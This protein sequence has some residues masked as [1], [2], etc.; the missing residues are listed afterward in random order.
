MHLLP[1]VPEQHSLQVRTAAH[2]PLTHS[3]GD[4]GAPSLLLAG[5]DCTLQDRALSP[6]AKHRPLQ[7][8]YACIDMDEEA[9]ELA[10]WCM[11]VHT[12]R[13]GTGRG[14][15]RVLFDFEGKARVLMDALRE[16]CAEKRFPNPRS[17]VV[18]LNDEETVIIK[19]E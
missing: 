9:D 17:W 5:R 16:H 8:V 19:W 2:H 11:E 14:Q 4:C 6:L 7:E 18:L 3:L 10:E 12:V 15:V 1:Y 13:T